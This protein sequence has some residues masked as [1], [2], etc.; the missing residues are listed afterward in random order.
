MLW[1]LGTIM[2]DECRILAPNHRDGRLIQ[3]INN[4][5]SNRLR[6]VDFDDI[7]QKGYEEN[8]QP[9]CLSIIDEKVFVIDYLLNREHKF[10][11]LE[12]HEEQSRWEVQA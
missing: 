7:P 1:I 10:E 9:V 11:F 8:Y 5:T 3:D 12:A 6:P 4:Q 2:L